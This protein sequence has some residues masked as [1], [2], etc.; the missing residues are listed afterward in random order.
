MRPMND[1]QRG[2]AQ[3]FLELGMLVCEKGDQ[4]NVILGSKLD[5]TALD[6]A[7]IPIVEGVIG[8][9][10]LFDH[11]AEFLLCLKVGVEIRD[12]AH[13]EEVKRAAP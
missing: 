2:G 9:V 3:D 10:V 7:G 12:G 11:T 8:D 6:I 4:S 1:F 5:D 13:L